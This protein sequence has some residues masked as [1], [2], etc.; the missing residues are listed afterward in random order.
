M[1]S[2][3]QLEQVING[4]N[5]DLSWEYAAMIQYIQHTPVCSRAPEYTAVIDELLEHAQEEHEHAVVLSDLIQYLG[6]IP[7]VEVANRLTSLNN[8][9][10]LRQ[11]LQVEYDAIRRYLQRIEQLEALQLYDSAQKIRNIAVVEQE[12]AIDLEKALGIQKVQSGTVY[13]FSHNP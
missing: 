1:T 6:G 9:E 10:M 11:D 7:T 5:L 8:V 4:L 12:H 3:I 2:Q 13:P